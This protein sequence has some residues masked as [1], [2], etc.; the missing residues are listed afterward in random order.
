MNKLLQELP[1]CPVALTVQIIASRWKLLIIRDLM[2]GTKRNS[3]LLHSLEGIS[4]KVLTNT[5]RD[6]EKLGLVNREVF[7]EV[8]PRVEYSLTPLGY[9]LLPLMMTLYAW[10]A[11]FQRHF[12]LNQDTVDNDQEYFA[13]IYSQLQEHTQTIDPAIFDSPYYEQ[14]MSF[15]NNLLAQSDF[16]AFVQP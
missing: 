7:A 3:E 15:I 13:Q 16:S 1:A 6:L 4:Q 14:Q 2:E 9:S 8:P 5:L 12:N 11:A 10:G